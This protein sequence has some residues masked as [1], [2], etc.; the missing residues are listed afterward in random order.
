MD[1]DLRERLLAAARALGPE[2][3]NRLAGSVSEVRSRGRLRYWQ[4]NLLSRLSADHGQVIASTTDFVAV[5]DGVDLI[6]IPRPIVTRDDF[7]A[8]PSRHYAGEAD[9]PPEWVRAAWDADT[10]FRQNVTYG[11]SREASKNGDLALAAG[12]LAYLATALRDDQAVALYLAV[13]HHS[14]HREIEF[15]PA[16]ARAFAVRM[17]VFPPPL[18]KREIVAALGEELAEQLG[19]P[20]DPAYLT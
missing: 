15:R 16:F 4:E 9:I 17:A 18:T 1:A 7:L 2:A 20:G 10:A 12:E 6:P 3:F 8:D 11:L 5:F 13:R 19:I 14:P